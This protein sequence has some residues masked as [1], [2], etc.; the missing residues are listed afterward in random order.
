MR[1]T[2]VTA[3]GRPSRSA[4]PGRIAVAVGL[5]LLV[6]L[7]AALVLPLPDGPRQSQR[8]DALSALTGRSSP[9]SAPRSAAMY[10]GQPL[11][12]RARGDLPDTEVAVV[13]TDSAQ[14]WRMATMARY[15]GT[16]WSPLPAQRPFRPAPRI[17]DDGRDAWNVGTALD[18]GPGQVFGTQ[19]GS[20]GTG[21]ATR[22]QRED[23]VRL[24]DRTGGFLLAPGHPLSVSLD[25]GGR[26]LAMG[27]SRLYATGDAGTARSYAVTSAVVPNAADVAGPR[28]GSTESGQLPVGGTEWLLLPD[29]VTARTVELAARITAGATT[30]GE[31]VGLIERYL[32]ST[33]PYRLDSPVPPDGQDAVDHFL[34]DARTGF[35]EQFAAAEVVMLR[36]LGVPARMATGYAFGE[37]TPDGR[38]LR[39]TNAHAWVEV[40]QPEQ[41]WLPSEP[42]ASAAAPPSQQNDRNQ[43]MSWIRKQL[44]SAHVRWALAGGL[45]LVGLLVTAAVVWIGRRRRRRV[46]VP[47]ADV[48]ALDPQTARLV[49]A[50]T[51]LQIA[52][53][54][55]GRGSPDAETLRELSGRVPEV[56]PR[57]F[58][59]A[60]RAIYGR[61]P[62]SAGA[63]RRGH[64][65]RR[66]RQSGRPRPGRG[67][68][69]CCRQGRTVLVRS[70]G[71]SGRPRRPP[72]PGRARPA[73]SRC[74]PR[75]SSPS[76]RSAPARRRSRCW[77][78]LPPAGRAP[79]AHGR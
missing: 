28:I 62:P 53:R 6:A 57:A 35:C 48:G 54:A 33:Y 15:D 17:D 39:G 51:G 20:A 11:D 31:Q 34:F 43:L 56:T 32:S 72:G 1:A 79:R 14:Y 30:R 8:M 2:I 42:T 68:R 46:P 41:G 74:A 18:D 4:L 59:T 9:S 52:L 19:S 47:F 77:T 60:E 26:V 76:P 67:A 10:Q 69:G 73:W 64:P 21:S 45:L 65:G 75:G 29:T 22:Q 61:R 78:G 55:A 13:P 12:M 44:A 40:W 38:L 70:P 49:E 36:S 23:R 25:D 7:V 27:G 16:T 24:L 63:D 66:H 50:L 5:S 3:D 58:A 71:L 37:P